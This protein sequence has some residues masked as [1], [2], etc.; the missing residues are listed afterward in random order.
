V[1]YDAP[2]TLACVLAWLTAHPQLP[3]QLRD[4]DV[5]RVS[6]RDLG[7]SDGYPY[8]RV[9][10]TP[11]GAGGLVWQTNSEIMLEA[12]DTPDNAA[13]Q[14]GDEALLAILQRCLWLINELPDADQPLEGRREVVTAV[15]PGVAPSDVP[16]P[17][18]PGQPRWLATVSVNAHPAADL[19][20]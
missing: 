12:L 9:R 15:G 7:G 2:D 20:H 6:S 13:L 4:G 10:L 19:P 8:L 18:V 17:G 1:T 11:A 16:D 14:L 5:A 3:E